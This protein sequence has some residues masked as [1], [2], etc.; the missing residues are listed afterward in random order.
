MK[1][2]LCG[3]VLI[4]MLAI[5]V[6][7][8]VP[9]TP[10]TPPATLVKDT[11][12]Y[13]TPNNP[14]LQAIPSN[15]ALSPDSAGYISHLQTFTTHCAWWTYDWSV[16]VFYADAST[17]PNK[18]DIN[19]QNTNRFKGQRIPSYAA[20]MP[21]GDGHCTIVN[22]VE[23]CIQHYWGFNTGIWDWYPSAFGAMAQP[24]DFDGTWR[25]QGGMPMRAGNTA[26]GIVGGG[27]WPDEL[28]SVIPRAQVFVIAKNHNRGDRYVDPANGGDGLGTCQYDM[29]QGM[30]IQ[31]NPSYDVSSLYT[32]ERVYAQALKTYGAFLS[33]SNN[34]TGGPMSFSGPPSKLSCVNNFFVGMFPDCTFNETATDI[35]LRY[36]RTQFRVL[37][38]GPYLTASKL[39]GYSTY[40]GTYDNNPIALAAPTLS[41]VSP[42][43]ASAGSTV[44]LTGTNL[45]GAYNIKFGNN[46]SWNPT[47][48][49][50]TQVRCVV[51]AGS[52]SVAVA[53]RTGGGQSGNVNF[54][55]G[56]GGNPPTLS[57][58]NPTSGATAGGTVCTLTG[59]NLTGCSA[60]SFGGTAASGVSVVSS[61]QVRCTSPAKSAGTYGVT[62]TTGGGTSNAVSYTYTQGDGPYTTTLTT[63]DDTFVY[64]G[65]AGTTHDGTNL[66]V[67]KNYSVDWRPFVKFDMSSVA[68]TTVTSAKLR[69][70]YWAPN[71][72]TLKVYSSADTWSEETLTW[73]NKPADGTLQ[74]SFTLTGTVGWYEIDL[75]SYVNSEFAGDKVVTF[76]VRDDTGGNGN[77]VNSQC[78]SKE[79][80]ASGGYQPR[81]VVISQ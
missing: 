75:T 74:A 23:G 12:T 19:I 80:G 2:K 3:A 14:S 69:L 55:Y 10:T 35:Q 28:T 63:N 5:W 71:A 17:A 44:T 39:S 73:N 60:V 27:V 46:N 61:T 22:T 57:S 77:N 11:V 31:M 36:D 4:C 56:T 30:R 62:A 48:V 64:N 8:C 72:Q 26:S 20:P 29:S 70:Y 78:S 79:T 16:P 41:S 45:T 51:P 52:G 49:S 76:V 50:S 25:A 6:V 65:Q 15:P 38:H 33:D 1:T 81:L 18:Q 32:F 37:A 59:A 43:T 24:R 42:S 67:Q 54:T 34:P 66:V 13:N 47:V 40:C 21:G 58:I 9:P 53:V 68:G 7:G